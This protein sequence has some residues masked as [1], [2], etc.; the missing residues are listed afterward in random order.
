M[1]IPPIDRTSYPNPEKATPVPLLF[2]DTETTSLRVPWRRAPRR[3]WEVGAIRREPDGS[4]TPYQCFVEDVNLTDADPLSLS[5][6]KFYDRHPQHAGGVV[7]GQ[8]VNRRGSI[9]GSPYRLAP[10][11]DVANLVAW[12]AR[13]AH[14]I[15]AV[16]D[17]DVSTLDQML[18]RHRLAWPAHYHLIC[19]EV[20][21]AGAIGWVPPY[22]SK[23]LSRALAVDPSHYAAHEALADAMWAR[24]LFDAARTSTR[25]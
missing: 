5:F 20:Y 15:G 10:E 18:E 6:G 25:R 11:E 3:V 7:L 19:A 12:L 4:E 21:A 13:G 17:F 22:D 16:P 2:L 23:E 8:P 14:I 24:D 1:Q 9:D